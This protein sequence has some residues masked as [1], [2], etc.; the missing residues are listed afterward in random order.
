[1]SIY[2]LPPLI[3]SMAL[4]SIGLFVLTKNI[5]SSVNLSF[6]LF[7][8]SVVGWLFCYTI[9]YSLKD[10]ISAEILGEA[11]CILVDFAG[12]FLYQFVVNFLK[13]KKEQKW[14]NLTYIFVLVL[15]LR[16]RCLL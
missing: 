1:M 13:L 16:P 6:F 15:F 4:L 10:P 8:L 14:V 12:P 11:G 2:S 7:C 5:R 9:V 3:G